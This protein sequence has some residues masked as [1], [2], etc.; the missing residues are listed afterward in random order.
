MKGWMNQ[1]MSASIY[2]AQ[3]PVRALRG[4]HA[5]VKRVDPMERKRYHQ[6]TRFSNDSPAKLAL[7]RNQPF[8]RSMAIVIN[9]VSNLIPFLIHEKTL[10]VVAFDN[11]RDCGGSIM[12]KA[13]YFTHNPLGSTK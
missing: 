8:T 11:K 12:V 7:H 6:F 3:E 4:G 5:L 1:P 2:D 9:T 13:K 10:Q